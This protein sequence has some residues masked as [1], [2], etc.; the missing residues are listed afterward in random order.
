MICN[1]EINWFLYDSLHLTVFFSI[2]VT[3]ISS[4]MQ[5]W[6]LFLLSVIFL[7]AVLCWWAYEISCIELKLLASLSVWSCQRCSN[8]VIYLWFVDVVLLPSHSLMRPSLTNC[9]TLTTTTPMYV[10]SFAPSYIYIAAGRMWIFGWNYVWN[11]AIC[12]RLRMLY[13]DCD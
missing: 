10:A 5:W 7:H 11:L 2:V 1:Y 8:V 4:N 12:C 6:L 3:L 9:H 13:K